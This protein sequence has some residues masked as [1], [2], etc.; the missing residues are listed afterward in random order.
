MVIEKVSEAVSALFSR[1]FS[2]RAIWAEHVVI[3]VRPATVLLPK[4]HGDIDLVM[5]ASMTICTVVGWIVFQPTLLSLLLAG[6]SLTS[7][8]SFLLSN[9]RANSLILALLLLSIIAS[10]ILF[11]ILVRRGNCV[12]TLD[13]TPQQYGDVNIRFGFGA[14]EG[15]FELSEEGVRSAWT[16]LRDT[17]FPIRHINFET[18]R[19]T[20][21]VDLVDPIA[22]IIVRHL[23]PHIGHKEYGS[24]RTVVICSV[25]GRDDINTGFEGN[26]YN[27]GILADLQ[28]G[29]GFG[30]IVYQPLFN[31]DARNA[32]G[33]QYCLHRVLDSY[34]ELLVDQNAP[35]LASQA[36]IRHLIAVP[37]AR[38]FS[39]T[40]SVEADVFVPELLYSDTFSQYNREFISLAFAY[41]LLPRDR[42]SVLASA[43]EEMR[44]RI[45]PGSDDGVPE[46]GLI[47]NPA[48]LL[49]GTQE[50]F[51]AL[52]LFG[53]IHRSIESDLP[54]VKAQ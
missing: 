28:S 7:L 31:V 18:A 6:F 9:L 24:P 39:N 15:Q 44:R 42:Q 52:F 33:F 12:V 50:P 51:I 36:S 47:Q 53:P 22:Q 35:P 3:E 38:E 14:R 54:Y 49:Y 19:L 43:A 8:F 46:M 20:F 21:N 37:A 11:Q 26:L 34:H 30:T 25:V 2:G 13:V 29:A 48:S 17:L 16:M 32:D 40:E 10:Y 45:E 23:V 27:Q 41:P 4:S 5:C 1:I